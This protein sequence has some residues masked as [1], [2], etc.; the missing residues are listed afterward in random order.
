MDDIGSIQ[1]NI[2]YLCMANVADMEYLMNLP[3]FELQEVIQDYL[4]VLEERGRR[5]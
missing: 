2:M 1:K 4:E 3:L 5:K